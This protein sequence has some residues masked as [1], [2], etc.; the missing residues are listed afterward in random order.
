M[1]VDSCRS[2]QTSIYEA[3]GAGEEDRPEIEA[4]KA[5][6]WGLLPGGGHFKVGESALGLAVAGLLIASLAF[7]ILMIGGN[8]RPVGI[9][10]LVFTV[11]AWAISIYDATRL[12]AGNEGATLLRPRVVTSAMGLVFMLVIVAAVSITGEGTAP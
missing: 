8:R 10:L 4:S 6:L 7:G 2:C 12:A 11:V 1:S 3:F 5:A 9:V